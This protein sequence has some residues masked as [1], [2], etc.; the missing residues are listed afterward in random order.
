MTKKKYS[1]LSRVKLPLSSKAIDALTDDQLLDCRICDLGLKIETSPLAEP[2]EQLYEEL[3]ERGIKARPHCWFS[4]EW[5]SPDGIPG[6]A[7]PFYLAHPRLVR[8]ERRQMKEVEGGTRASLMK[9]L[10][11]EA[12]H[13]I[14]TAFRLHRKRGYREVFGNYF[15]PYPEYYRPRP[16]SK[17]FV[18]HLEPWYAQSHPSEDFAETF[19]VWLAPGKRWKND[20]RGWQCGCINLNSSMR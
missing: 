4:D 19:A 15:A 12:G 17:S 2:I 16:N 11:H 13:A 6:I 1:P 20:Y 5:F 9:I 3:A 18:T 7:I 8:L 10:R 14:D